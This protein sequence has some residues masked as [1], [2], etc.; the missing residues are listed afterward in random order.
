LLQLAM[1]SSGTVMLGMWSDKSEVSHYALAW[2]TAALISFVL[3]AVNTI[4]QPKFAGFYARGEME[5]LAITARKANVLMTLSAVPISL[6]FLVA[7]TF[8]MG[9]FGED[10]SQGSLP[11]QILS[12]AQF[13]NVA[14][15]SVGVLLVMS[16]KEREYRNALVVSASIVLLLNVA[17][18]PTHGAVG[19]AA[20]AAV[21]LVS[22]NVLFAY[23]VWTR[24]G[25]VMFSSRPYRPKKE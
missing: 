24:L 13:V 9:L 25:I 19:A 4:A 5:R 2:R 14:M 3:V 1:N 15:G 6:V 12:V 20:A 22:Q 10:F 21:G 18:I 16:A 7:P 11:L 23:Y 17:L 8:V